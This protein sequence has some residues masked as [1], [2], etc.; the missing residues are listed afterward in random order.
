MYDLELE[1]R[2]APRVLERA[3][4]DA[5][6]RLERAG[7]DRH[8]RAEQYPE[9]HDHGA[10]P[11]SADR[12]TGSGTAAGR[13]RGC[14]GASAPPGRSGSTR[15]ASSRSRCRARPA[16]VELAP[17]SKNATAATQ[18]D[19]RHDADI[20]LTRTGV[21]SLRL[22]T[23]NQPQNAPSYAATACTRSEPIIHTAPDVIE[24]ADEAERHQDQQ[25][26]RSAAVDREHLGDR[27]DEAADPGHLV[28][29]QHE[30]DAEDRDHVA[31]HAERRAAWKT[32]TGT[33]RL[34]FSI[35]SAAPFCSSKPT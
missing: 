5:E 26:V 21:P 1:P 22:N 15:A 28:E 20:T 33:S 34:G 3:V 30:Q 29:R 9:R 10:D 19:R 24:A 25:R 13:G 8:P 11:D 18:N 12:R 2:D 17:L 7:E 14:S 23:P 35:S 4:V 16:N 6:Q 27:V 32:E 31:Q